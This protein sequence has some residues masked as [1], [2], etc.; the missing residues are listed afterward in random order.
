MDKMS[1]IVLQQYL[2]ALLATLIIGLRMF[3]QFLSTD[4]LTYLCTLYI[5]YKFAQP[6]KFLK[7]EHSSSPLNAVW[8][9]VLDISYN[10][11]FSF[12]FSNNI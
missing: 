12:K 2:S 6:P 10:I 9:S 4:A 1:S 8:Y 5:F 11:N 3:V 7:N